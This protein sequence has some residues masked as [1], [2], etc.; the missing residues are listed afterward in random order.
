MSLSAISD[1][2]ERT[3][4]LDVSILGMESLGRAV[5]ERMTHSGAPDAGAYYRELLRSS[6][7]LQDLVEEV[8]VP[9]TWFY[10]DLEPFVFLARHAAAKWLTARDREVIRILSVPCSTGEEPYSI[11]MTLMDAGLSPRQFE[12]DACDISRRAVLT[13]ARS[14]YG[15]NSFR[16]E[17]PD[18]RDRHF[19]KTESGYRLS[20]AVSRSVRFFQGNMVA[21]DFLSGSGRYDAIFCRNLCIYLSSGARDRALAAVDRLLAPSGLLFVG[22]AEV[23][24]LWNERF[25]TVQHPKSFAY[26]RRTKSRSETKPVGVTPGSPMTSPDRVPAAAEPFPQRARRLREPQ[27]VG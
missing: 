7:E 21:P 5:L 25:E 26:R 9:E 17:Q 19:E 1:L 24:S 18:F 16:G 8:V 4:G 6:D 23:I 12:I 11:A 15:K 2:L 27:S 10:R 14:L 3:I 13:A 22:H 20:T